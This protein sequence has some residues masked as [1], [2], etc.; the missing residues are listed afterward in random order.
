METLTIGFV[1][2]FFLFS[3]FEYFHCEGSSAV[4]KDSLFVDF[5]LFG[6]NLGTAFFQLN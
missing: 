2:S 3:F 1:L 5:L 4:E 6:D